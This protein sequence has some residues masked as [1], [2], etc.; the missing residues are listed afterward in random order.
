VRVSPD[1]LKQI[2]AYFRMGAKSLRQ[3][4]HKEVALIYEQTAE[5]IED[6]SADA[7]MIDTLEERRAQ[8]LYSAQIE[9]WQ[10]ECFDAK[11][12]HIFAPRHT[13]RQ[14]FGAAL[15]GEKV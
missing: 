6:L 8:L 12:C 3:Q 7:C 9:R 10:V 1:E 2:I 14:A 5:I 13:P 11:G 15:R 4:K